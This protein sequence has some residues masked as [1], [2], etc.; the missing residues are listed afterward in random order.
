MN[1]SY[2]AVFITTSNIEEARR[3]SGLLLEKKKA[4]CVSIINVLSS[5][6]WWQGK[7]DSA[8]E[9]LLIAKTR[10]E[11]LPALVDLVKSAHSYE[12]PEIIALPII[13]GNPDYLDWLTRNTACLPE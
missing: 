12:V 2:V 6:F 10:A 7:I 8:A 1:N 11:A 3:I 4:A 9:C 5:S 13:G